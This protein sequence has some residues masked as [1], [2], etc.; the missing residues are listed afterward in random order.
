MHINKT[1]G[2]SNLINMKGIGFKMAYN[3]VKFTILFER[4]Q[5]GLFVLRMFLASSIDYQ[6]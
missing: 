5:N 1:W 2:R 4:A 6:H 3:V